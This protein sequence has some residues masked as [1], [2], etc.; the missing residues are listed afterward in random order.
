MS[1]WTDTE[2]TRRL[3]ISYPIFQGPFGRGG[4]ST[5]LAATVSNAGGLGS[6]GSNDQ[7]PAEIIKIA[8]ENRKLSGKP[9]GMNLWVST[10]DVGGES[11]PAETYERVTKLLEPY[12][13]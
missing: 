4:S 6:Y 2:I 8:G 10:F 1:N 12:Y 11:L 7:G 13:K 5:L 9:F 3:N